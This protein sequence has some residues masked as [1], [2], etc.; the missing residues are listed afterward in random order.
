[1]LLYWLS[2][3]VRGVYLLKLA[4][5]GLLIVASPAAKH[6]LQVLG[7]HELWHMGSLVVVHGLSCSLPVESSRT[8]AQTH[9][10]AGRF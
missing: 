2:L 8:R 9:A 1:M 10:L 5:H 7:L 4:V 6:T 3:L